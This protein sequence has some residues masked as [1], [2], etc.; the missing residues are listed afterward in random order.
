MT[1]ATMT[2]AT[3]TTA[4]TTNQ[5]ILLP[6]EMFQ[7]EGDV[8]IPDF[9]LGPPPEDYDEGSERRFWGDP[10]NFQLE[11]ETYWLRVWN[12]EQNY[13]IKRHEQQLGGVSA[14]SA[15]A[16]Q[17][18]KLEAMFR[19]GVFDRRVR[20]EKSLAWRKGEAWWAVEDW[21]RVMDGIE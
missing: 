6:S 4:T 1:T 19:D 16:P 21:M 13:R 9:D 3:M 20:L 7:V 12:H 2:T 15:A 8:P 18:L 14:Y 17:W 11:F 5:T 10:S